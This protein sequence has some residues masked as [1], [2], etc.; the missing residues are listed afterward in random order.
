MFDLIQPTD[1]RLPS[2]LKAGP[3][4]L[5]RYAVLLSD[6]YNGDPLI[7]VVA[8]GYPVFTYAPADGEVGTWSIL[9]GIDDTDGQAQALAGLWERIGQAFAEGPTD[10]FGSTVA[11]VGFQAASDLWETAGLMDDGHAICFLTDDLDQLT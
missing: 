4:D 1:P 6:D 11:E 7:T 8:N 10:T 3:S 9:L 5:D 2:I